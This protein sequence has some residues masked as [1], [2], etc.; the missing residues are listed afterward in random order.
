MRVASLASAGLIGT[1]LLITIWAI[2]TWPYHREVRG[3]TSLIVTILFVAGV[4][5]LILGIIGEYIGR[6][7]VEVKRRPLYLVRQD[8]AVDKNG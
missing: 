1:A 7:F 3:W 5:T 2:I 8:T 4:Q 6:L